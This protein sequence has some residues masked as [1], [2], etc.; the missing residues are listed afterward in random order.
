MKKNRQN[1]FD[2]AEFIPNDYL[3]ELENYNVTNWS[4][5]TNYFLL[6]TFQ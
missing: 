1:E 5:Q 2:R 6:F 4:K 3:K